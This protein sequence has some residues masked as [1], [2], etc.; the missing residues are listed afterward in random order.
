MD[1]RLTEVARDSPTLSREGRAIVLQTIASM[2]WKLRSFD[3]KTAFLRGKADEK[4]PLAMAMEPSE[5]LRKLLGLSSDEVCALLGNAYSRVDAP[6]LFYRELSKQLL[7]L[8]FRHHPLDPCIF[9]LETYEQ[10]QRRLRGVLGTHVDD[11]VCGGDALCEEK[12]QQ[13]KS[14]PLFGSE[15]QTSFLFTGICLEEL[16]SPTQCVH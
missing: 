14:R 5:E 4:N 13:L 11:G 10:G 16:P 7:S 1:P 15:K 3:I 12:I 8:G 9:L 6:L 2:R